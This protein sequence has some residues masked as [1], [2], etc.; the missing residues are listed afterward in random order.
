M[1][2]LAYLAALLW[3]QGHAREAFETSERSLELAGEVG[4]PVTLALAWGMRCAL[5]VV[6]GM[7]DELR[8]WLARARIHSVERNIGYWSN[9]CSMW[10][11]WL[12]TV[13]GDVE[14]GTALLERHLDAY[15]ASGGRIG[16]AS[17][18]CLLAAVHLAAGRP[19]P[20]LEVLS[21][22]QEHIEAAGE[23][24]FEPEIQWLMAR[25]LM[26]PG[27]PDP[28]AAGAAYERAAQ[29]AAGQGARL[30]ELRAATGL[31]LLQRKAGAASTSM[32]RIESLCE[33][34]GAD[35]ALPEV[36]RARALLDGERAA[37]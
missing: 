27:A 5:L 3:I 11:A 21:A 8:G 36:R 1:S 28:A 20:A 18:N 10:S 30:W 33:W 19:R 17:F 6:A 26:A 22:G 34:F 4:G 13:D 12:Q 15:R 9:V 2:A 23:R 14:G 32:S 16:I 37:G 25:A 31:A 35:S 29:S 7:R 24:Y